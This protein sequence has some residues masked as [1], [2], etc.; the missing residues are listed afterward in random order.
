MTVRI[1]LVNGDE[2]A[3]APIVEALRSMPWDHGRPEIV[4]AASGE[5]ALPSAA[6]QP[7]DLA[8]AELVLPRPGISGADTLIR[9]R[10]LCPQCRRLLVSDHGY[11]RELVQG[12]A[13]RFLDRAGGEQDAADLVA[14][15]EELLPERLAD[16]LATQGVLVDDQAAG[17]GP[18]SPALP[19]DLIGGKY[20]AL[21][22]LNHACGP[23]YRAEDTSLKRQV[24]I[25]LLPLGSVKQAEVAKQIRRS[26]AA[27]SLLT[28]PNIVAVHDAGI[29]GEE[30]YVVTEMMIGGRPLRDELRERGA[31]P[32][33]EAIGIALSVLEALGH[34][35][36]LGVVHGDLRPTN[37]LVTP[38]G[39]VKVADFGLGRLAS[40][41]S[42]GP[43]V[44]TAV[45]P[46]TAGTV[47]ATVGYMA[48]EQVQ[49]RS[50]DHRADLFA[51]GAILFE[52]LHG[53]ALAR[54]V[55]PFVRAAFLDVDRLPQKL[56]ELPAGRRLSE[57][58]EQ[59]LAPSLKRRY[60]SCETFAE[61]LRGAGGPGWSRVLRW[62]GRKV[63][64]EGT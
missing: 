18:A 10:E 3:R 36:D 7:F 16:E 56:P 17:P 39:E 28:H 37:I 12:A 47:L 6:A 15:V 55:S 24:A 13:D 11:V 51:L 48:P 42:T 1:L 22:K 64:K 32:R 46:S 45:Q 57:V 53:K 29:E 26:M 9:V 5:Q 52:M 23:V 58:L 2:T 54:V 4:E 30:I 31:L 61:D 25:E 8:V 40:F 41:G 62:M 38:Q 19:P 50:M 44:S 21:A 20:R 63:V 33:N 14:A 59:A 43:G 34:A 27:A 60:A 49:G 35:H